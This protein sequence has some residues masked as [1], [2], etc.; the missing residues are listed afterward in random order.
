MNHDDRR[1]DFV[2]QRNE[3]WSIE[4]LLLGEIPDRRDLTR[5][6]LLHAWVVQLLAAGP[7]GVQV[8]LRPKLIFLLCDVTPL[9][10]LTID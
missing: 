1:T 7:L 6:Q 8:R 2:E 3:S 9:R 4:H 5:E 10:I